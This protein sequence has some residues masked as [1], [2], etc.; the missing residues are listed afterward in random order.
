MEEQSCKPDIKTYTPLLKLCCRRQWVKTL[1]FLICHMYRKDITPDFSTYTLLVSWLGRNGRLTQS[2]LFLEEMV[3]KG[4]APQ[5]ETF[6]LV[7]DKLKK[8]DMLSAVRKIQLLR[9]HTEGTRCRS[10]VPS[11]LR[12]DGHGRQCYAVLS[13]TSEAESWNR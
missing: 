4:F 8:M 11:Y 2:C 3:L 6:D 1:L 5:Q 10:G 13:N 9:M 12:E 7:L